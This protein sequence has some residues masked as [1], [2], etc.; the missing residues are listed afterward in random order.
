STA[1]ARRATLHTPIGDAASRKRR[2]RENQVRTGLIA[3]GSRIRT[4]GPALEERP[5]RRST[6][7]S[8]PTAR[9]DDNPRRDRWFEAPFLERRVMPRRAAGMALLSSRGIGSRR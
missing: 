7:V 4:I 2:S 8:A 5:F 9:I 3:G 6:S 1:M